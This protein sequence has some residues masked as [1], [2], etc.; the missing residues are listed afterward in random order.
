MRAQPPVVIIMG[1]PGSGKS[2]QARAVAQRFGFSEFDTGGFIRSLGSATGPLAEW[3]R[4]QY[5]T[6]KLAPP[7]LIVALVSQELTRLLGEGRAVILHGSPRT[8]R[9]AE[10]EWRV[11]ATPERAGRTFLLML[12][13]P[14]NVAQRRIRERALS[15]GRTDD[16]EK[17]ME[18]RW[19]EYVFR[20][21][22]AM[23]SV[24]RRLPS[25]VVDGNRSIDEVGRDVVQ[26][27]QKHF[28]LP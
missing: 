24:A 20:T 11:L 1:P 26:A 6:G 8:L 15:L 4:S 23:R 14:K 13:T 17:G 28:D 12:R 10:E 18:Q 25:A 19:E 5:A 3:F 2:T 22:P 27:V 7:P 9:E 16:T 21:E